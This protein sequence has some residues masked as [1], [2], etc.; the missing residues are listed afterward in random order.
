MLLSL[1]QSGNPRRKD[2]NFLTFSTL[3][4]PAEKSAASIALAITI[5]RRK[6]P[7]WYL[8]TR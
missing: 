5:E 8:T 6:I 4:L 2:H 3:L 1:P 7:E